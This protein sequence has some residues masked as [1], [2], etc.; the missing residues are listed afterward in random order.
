MATPA[1]PPYL[2]GKCLAMAFRG[3]SFQCVNAGG[4][5]IACFGDAQLT[6]FL[7]SPLV[8]DDLV[9]GRPRA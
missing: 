8:Y 3:N 2:L 7:V 9:G 6:D 5:S 1:G 4:D